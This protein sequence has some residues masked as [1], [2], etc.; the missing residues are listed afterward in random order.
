MTE[1]SVAAAIFSVKTKQCSR[2]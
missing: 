1:S 2:V